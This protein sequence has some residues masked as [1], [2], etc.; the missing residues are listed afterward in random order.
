[1]W[2]EKARSGLLRS[3]S[4]LEEILT[5]LRKVVTE[6][7]EGIGSLDSLYDLGIS[8]GSYLTNKSR[9]L[10]IDEAKLREAIEKDPEAVAKVFLKE[11]DNEKEKG[12]MVRLYDKI[13]KGINKITAK[14]GNA[15]STYDQSTIGKTIRDIDDYIAT[16]EERLL[17]IEESYW[18]RFTAMERAIS[19]MNQQSSWLAAQLGGGLS[20]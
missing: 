1:M 4:L 6:T 5:D 8:A 3:D 10:K 16:L 13:G 2:E 17:R 7:V 18:R 12:I 9:I 19:S 11:S 20:K 14:A 15:T